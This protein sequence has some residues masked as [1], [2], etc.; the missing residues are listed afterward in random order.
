MKLRCL[1]DDEVMLRDEP[2]V[3]LPVKLLAC[4]EIC[5]A[6][7]GKSANPLQVTL[8]R[9]HCSGERREGRSQTR[10][11]RASFA[12]ESDDAKECSYTMPRA[13]D[14]RHMPSP[15]T[16]QPCPLCHSTT[17]TMCFSIP[18]HHEPPS[19]HHTKHRKSQGD[20]AHGYVA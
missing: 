18:R 3:C 16:C 14:A 4:M 13:S 1:K 6:K 20:G 10:R 11:K 12:C 9:A 8:W 15:D 19:A 17:I 2:F 5:N 7:L